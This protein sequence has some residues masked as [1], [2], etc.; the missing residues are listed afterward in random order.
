MVFKITKLDYEIKDSECYLKINLKNITSSTFTPFLAIF[1]TETGKKYFY[2]SVNPIKPNEEKTITINFP[3]ERESF[4]VR[5]W[6]GYLE[7]K[8]WKPIGF[9]DVFISLVREG[10][11]MKEIMFIILGLI[12]GFAI[13]YAITKYRQRGKVWIEIKR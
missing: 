8:G 12:G 2:D 4:K 3:I 5:I 9:K 1:D 10:L 11:K 7:E 13:M 6:Y